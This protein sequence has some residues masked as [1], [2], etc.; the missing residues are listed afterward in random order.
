MSSSKQPLAVYLHDHLAGAASA[1]D[2]VGS[3]RDNF[4]GQELG[5]FAAMLFAEIAADKEMLH[6]LASQLGPGSDFLKDSAAWV[7]EKISRFK[8]A[9]DDPTG[10][11]VIRGPRVLGVGYPWKSIFVARPR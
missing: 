7:A 2:L 11:G 1:L 9:H 3:M 8:L 6:S 4:R 10:L 5:E